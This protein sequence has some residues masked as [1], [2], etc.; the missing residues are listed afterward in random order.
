M[1]F[2]PDGK[3]LASAGLDKKVKLWELPAGKPL[4]GHTG[5]VESVSVSPDE[6]MLASASQDMTVRLWDIPSGNPINCL[7]DPAAL[8]SDQKVDQYTATGAG[9]RSI[10][11]TLPCGSP[12]PAG[13]I[14]TCNCLSGTGPVVPRTP[15]APPYPGG[16]TY[17]SCNKICTSCVPIQ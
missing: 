13:A 16:T 8:G 2:S 10:A 3:L 14:C 17:C 12:V 7:L 9:G 11:Y 4:E 15:V 1:S 5:W 6:R